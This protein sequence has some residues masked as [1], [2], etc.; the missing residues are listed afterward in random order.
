MYK[1]AK[2]R[3]IEDEYLNKFN[4]EIYG[5][6]PILGLNKT[7]II[8]HGISNEIAIKNMIIHTKDVIEADLSV[9]IKQNLN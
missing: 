9:K 3:N 5:G 4:Y 2:S 6:T 8:G 1:I 7:V